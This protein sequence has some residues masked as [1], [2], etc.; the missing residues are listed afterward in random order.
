MR[1]AN[2][3]IMKSKSSWYIAGLHFDC[4]QCGNC[5]SGPDEGYI[6]ITKPEIKFIADFLKEPVEQVQRKY[7]R[8]VGLRR[9]IVEQAATRDCIFA[10]KFDGRKKCAIYPVRPNQ[11]R[12]WPFWSDNLKSENTWNEAAEKCSGINRGRL[13]SFEEIDRIKGRKRWWADEQ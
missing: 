1:G 2:V 11:C 10:R 5:C 9:T 7:L 6:W 8:R 12:T 13:Y 3:N 4:Q